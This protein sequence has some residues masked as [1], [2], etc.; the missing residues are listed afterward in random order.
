MSDDIQLDLTAGEPA[1]RRSRKSD[2]PSLAET[3][4][5]QR[6]AQGD[7][8]NADPATITPGVKTALA[9]I[10]AQT[11]AQPM[12]EQIVIGTQGVDVNGRDLVNQI[13]G[14]VQATQAI[15]KLSQTIG[16]TKLAFVKE[17]KAYK[18]L[19]GTVAPNGLVLSGTWEEFC[20]LLGISD[21]K[22]NTDIAN[23]KAFGEEALES[24]T[25]MGV[26]YRDLAQYRKL[27]TDEK[28]ALIEAAKAGDKEQLLDL[29][30]ML[31]EKHVK[32]K[33]ELADKAAV[34]EQDLK[35][36]GKRINNMN[37]EIERSE[38][39]LSRLKSK[40]R[41]TK[42]E[43][44]T[45]DVRD[46]CMHLQ[47]GCELNLNSLHKLFSDCFY[48]EPTPE[49][50]LRIEQVYVAIKVSASRAFD[51]LEM[52]QDL[53]ANADI[54]VDRIQGQHIL[55]PEEAERWMLDA[56]MLESRHEAEKLARDVKRENDRPKGRG[57]PAGSKNKAE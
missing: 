29:A 48:A 40:Q 6:L 33:T 43:D 50:R 37:A 20:G 35:A 21:E 16:V 9:E 53:L 30:E 32:E 51:L 14:Q 11:N 24:M 46:E 15:S 27:P 26:G 44:Y 22:A 10:T 18:A 56:Q 8:E 19:K 28:T 17:T 25:R 42:F 49:Q 3:L 7:L 52:T 4:Y 38:S 41:L 57:R 47:A 45:E 2:T 36:A 31:I 1:P 5:A 13:L 39:E 34:L 54:H 55:T 23:L 12:P